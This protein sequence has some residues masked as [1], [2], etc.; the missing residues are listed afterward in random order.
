MKRIIAIAAGLLAAAACTPLLQSST[1]EEAPLFGFSAESSR[2]ERQWEEKFK[3]IP[4]PENLR[5]YMRRLTARP[6]NV[7]S[8]YDKDNAEWIAAKFKEFGLE[9]QIENFDVLYPTPKERLIEL[10][11]GAPYFKA[12]MQEPAVP[13]DPTSNQQNEQLPTY[14]AY[15]IDGD[16]TAELVYVNYGLPR[17]YEELDRLG[18]SVKGKIVIARYGNSWRGIKPKVAAE[19]GAIGCLIYS[20][21][22]DDGFFQE[23]V[24]PDGPMRN[25]NGVQR[26]SVMDMPVYPGD[27]TTPGVGSK[28]DVKRLALKDIP[29]LTK[30]PTLPISYGDAKPLLAALKGP[31]A[32]ES[33]RG[34]LPLTYH[35]G[36]GP[37]RVHLKVAFNWDI[38]PVYDVVFKIPG[39][40]SPDQ[41]IVRGNHHD[42]WVNGAEDPM[43]LGSTEWAEYHGDEL[44][45]HAALYIN[46]DGNGRGFLGVEGSHSLE[47][48]VNTVARDITDPEKNISV[49]K[50]GQAARL[51]MGRSE[52][53]KEARTRPDLRIGPLGS[54]SDYTTFIDHLGIASLNVAFSGEDDGGIYHS[55]Y[56]DFYWFTKFSDK[57][58]VYGRALSQTV[59]TMVLRFADADVLPYDFSDFADTIHKYNDELKKLLK[60]KQEQ[61]H[62]RNQDID[63]GVYSA[64]SDPRRPTVAP[65]KEEVPPF[66]NFAPLDNAQNAVDK[67][68]QRYTKAAKAFAGGS[69]APQTLQALNAKLLQAERKLTNP[70]GLPR[71]PWFKHLI[72][73]PG[74]YTGYGAKTLPGVREGIEEK[75]YQE[76]EKEITRVSK[77]LQ[78][79]ADAIDSAAADLE[80][81]GH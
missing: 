66:L 18:V 36:P 59:G 7:G 19:H 70:D 79:Y 31:V 55:I 80:K 17:D 75:R 1:G 53:R 8:P 57:D 5:E 76:A 61:V 50:R 6:H 21:P 15:S 34:A 78:D 3:A 42:G 72:Y 62:D 58:F 2:A 13:Q 63:D 41:W 47:K 45:Q 9:T 25:E 39:S 33:F 60:D 20:D 14:N 4:K 54:G 11:E 16:V 56:D 81:A 71:R 24:F 68:A 67:S 28:G 44:K 10:V 52:D 29:T 26:G 69:A 48:F 49:W 35:V 27:P 22:R 32:P 12:K 77:A 37:A 73:A 23:D 43:L 51:T 38:K 46:T 64:A 74:F 40:E 30:I 65:P